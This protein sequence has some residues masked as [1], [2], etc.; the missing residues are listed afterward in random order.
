MCL[1]P[2]TFHLNPGFAA[3]RAPHPGLGETQ[4][5]DLTGVG[6]A[7]DPGAVLCQQ[8]QGA[9]LKLAHRPSTWSSA[10]KPRERKSMAVALLLPSKPPIRPLLASSNPE[11]CKKRNSGK[12]GITQSSKLTPKLPHL[13]KRPIVFWLLATFPVS[14]D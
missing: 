1:S 5:E 9:D 11:P 6:R 7:T 12:Y 4:G 14:F 10:L 2:A 8:A 3:A 13:P